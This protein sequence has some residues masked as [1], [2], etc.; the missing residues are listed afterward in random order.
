MVSFCRTGRF[1]EETYA[2]PAKLLT[3]PFCSRLMNRTED[4]QA[5]PAQAKSTHKSCD[6]GI[7]LMKEK[8]DEVLA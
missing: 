4:N 2:A 8:A 1:N 7:K 3:F 5:L 6:S